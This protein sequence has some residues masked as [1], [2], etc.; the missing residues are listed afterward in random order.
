MVGAAGQCCVVR[1]AN[2]RRSMSR[3]GVGVTRRDLI[4]D[5]FC[6]EKKP[7]GPTPPPP[8]IQESTVLA[9]SE[10]HSSGG[11]SILTLF[12]MSSSDQ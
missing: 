9:F 4:F 8:P 2:G 12:K 5:A 11:F 3:V 6:N 7:Q 10:L 1:A